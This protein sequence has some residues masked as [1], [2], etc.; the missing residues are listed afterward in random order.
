MRKR[1]TRITSLVAAASIAC[2][3][4]VSPVGTTAYAKTA[5]LTAEVGYNDVTGLRVPTLA[6]DE[7]SISLVWDKPEKYDNIADYNI[8]MDGKLVGTAR[9]S[10]E[11]NAEWASAYMKSFYEGY[12]KKDVD[13]VNVDIHSYKATGLKPATEYK[14]EVRPINAA[15]KELGTSQTI[16]Q[17][18]AKTANVCNIVDFGAAA[19]E[20]G[21]TYY[22]DEINQL[23][24]K[25]TKAIQAA[26]DACEEGGTVVIPKGIYMSGAI[27]LKSNMTLELEEG[28]ILWGSPNTDHYEHNYL[29]YPYSTDT[30]AWALV[31]AY[32]ADENQMLENIRITGQGTI[33]GN[34]FK[35]GKADTILGDG[36]SQVQ[37]QTKNALDPTDEKYN[38]EQ[39]VS[40][41]NTKVSDTSTDK[42]M[43]TNKLNYGV[44]AKDAF[45][46]A[47]KEGKNDTVA[48]A[49]RP[50]LVALRGVDGIYVEGVTFKNPAFH[51][52][53]ILDS[54]NV[55]S[56]DV[57]YITYD[58]N[59]ADG[60]EIGNT[61]NSMIYNNFFDT[62]DDSIN[63][64]TGLGNGVKDSAQHP[65]S[66][67]WTFNNFIRNGHGGA[68]AAGSHTGAGICNMLVEDNVINL[69]EMPFRF[70]SAP[71]NGGGIYNITIRDT[72]VANCKQLFVMTTSYG[73]ANQ[74]FAVEPA[75]KPAEFYNIS[76]YNIT[77]DT[78][79][80]NS[81]YLMADVS[82]TYKPW[83][84]HHN[85]YF[86]DITCT[87]ITTQKS[88]LITGC[89]DVEFKNVSLAWN[90]SKVPTVAPWSTITYSKDIK[91]TGTT[92]LAN[93]ANNAM[94]AP[95]W[96]A[97][98]MTGE[99]QVVDKT[100]YKSASTTLSWD[101]AT[102]DTKV[103][104]YSVDVYVGDQKVDQID[105]ITATTYT[106]T[107]LSTAVDYTYKV[108]AS[109]ATG[110]KTLGPVF[111]QKSAGEKDQAAIIAPEKK[112]VE[113]S[114][115]GYTWGLATFA[116]AKVTDERV[117]GYK[118]YLNGK[119]T[120]TF[121]NYK[122]QNAQ[123]SETISQN[124]RRMTAGKDN[125]V[126]IV[127]FT[128]ADLVAEYAQS[129]VK[130]TENY[131]FKAPVWAK[132]AK[133]NV[134][135]KGSDVVLSWPKAS[136]DTEVLGYRVYVDGKA[137]LADA[138]KEFNQVNGNCT[139]TDTTYTV[140]GLDLTKEHTF[141][142]EAGDT[143]WKAA[144]G[145]GPFHWTFSGPSATYK[146][147][148]TP[149]VPPAPATTVAEVKGFKASATTATTVSLS[150][151]KAA[152]VSGYQLTYKDAAGKTITKN[153]KASEVSCK[154]SGLCPATS[155]AYSIKA[156]KTV[157][158]KPVYSKAVTATVKTKE[159]AK[160]TTLNATKVNNQSMT[161][162]WKAAAEA[163]GYVITYKNALNKNTTITVTSGTKTSVK[164]SNLL[165]NKSYKFTIKPYVL[166]NGKKVYAGATTKSFK[167]VKTVKPAK[168]GSV[169]AKKASKT[170]AKIT[171]K[172][173]KNAAGYEIAYST[174]KSSGF[175]K[176]N[177]GTA[178][179]KTISK[180]KSKGTYYVK[181]C[182]FT[183]ENKVV[184]GKVVKT[185]VYGAY[186][187]VK[188][189]SLR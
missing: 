153:L 134:A 149:V 7:T 64:A 178:S 147:T 177:A 3:M 99:T 94:T 114:G 88:E 174:K 21:Y 136:D 167:T 59:N 14:F 90:A 79:S 128:D 150:W 65:S 68:I 143:W 35:Y 179:K 108:Y 151:T 148:A 152:D 13:M 45:D 22:N 163:N 8:Y 184:K 157:N 74:A 34:G 172:T 146:Q 29:L 10:Y 102:D 156:F 57:K 80:K 73:D 55:V 109:D 173:V 185:K 17:T 117:R 69:N 77:A 38:L 104:S 175:K 93:N 20:K 87:N 139:T 76:A 181:V 18:T 85:L 92:T 75:D 47:K 28:A 91:F 12:A 187:S 158:N 97:T 52:L 23:I 110:N 170:S 112:E 183:Y 61:E 31:N 155:Y 107:G 53:A 145:E 100:S 63:F 180:L 46:K 70:K 33:Y 98:K 135:Q 144:A 140:K 101:A 141:K 48:Y 124:V 95:T 40:A 103:A 49:S 96:A 26:I 60:I 164:V 111:I 168:V 4:F 89:D 161:L 154:V 119:E 129:T 132:N 6:Y 120:E 162:N 39:W 25:N 125:T 188:K 67:I 131:D 36:V 83:H 165:A 169:S 37:Y 27:Y 186:S 15:G 62:G 71:V 51:T 2:S 113:F 1:M 160:V 72:A 5:R 32:S 43:D 116:N 127:A 105:G 130:T 19:S 176:V 118:V 56:T 11:K 138:N 16:R 106:V 41:S 142:V 123:T 171:Y 189:V 58:C 115:V 84:T 50:N 24:V 166:V 122:I 159:L 44:L 54:K 86:E 9:E 133:L 78:I 30:R 82:A 182:A 121:Y 66:N 126:K 42:P 137:V 81:F